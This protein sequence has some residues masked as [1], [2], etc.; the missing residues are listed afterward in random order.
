MKNLSNRERIALGPKPK[1]HK[2]RRYS[3]KVYEEL[4][5]ARKRKDDAE[6]K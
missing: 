1:R 3:R 6:S 5:A 2:K 4:A